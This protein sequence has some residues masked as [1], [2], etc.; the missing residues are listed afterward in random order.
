MNGEAMTNL[1]TS[2]GYGSGDFALNLF[3]QGTGFYLFFYFTDVVG[4]P[5]AVAGTV[6]AIGG[7]WDAITDPAMGYIAERTKSRW[8][9]YRPYLL[10]GSVPLGLS[11]VL[12]FSLPAIKG[13]AASWVVALLALLLFRTC[14]T[15]VSIPYST[16]GARMTTN[17]D[18]RTHLSAIRMYCAFLGGMAV[19]GAAALLQSYYPDG[20]VFRYLGIF[21]AVTGTIVL[22]LC[23]RY[24]AQRVGRN[25]QALPAT[26]FRQLM[27]SLMS[28]R[29]FL[30][31]LISIVFVSAATTVVTSTVL[32]IFEYAFDDRLMGNNAILIMT[33]APL[34][35]IPIWSAVAL[36]FGKKNTWITG[37]AV[38]IIGLLSLYFYASG[39][40]YSALFSYGIITLGLSSFSVLFWSMLPDTIEYGEYTTGVRNESSIIGFVSSAQKAALAASVFL[41][42]LMLDM[43]GY[44][45]G[46]E[47]TSETLNG[48]LTVVC[49]APGLAMVG[50]IIAMVYYP[51]T[52]RSHAEMVTVL[53]ENDG[54]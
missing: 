33:G 3:W 23:F 54:L 26:S 31:L 1:K 46:V 4:L 13:S 37:C 7:L 38:T 6:F 25:T 35:T 5:N 22:F 36:K 39:S 29:P 48:L 19:I 20:E 44:S 10:F 21:C 12:L 16:L 50:A 9:R 18:E 28:N 41:L 24:T 17:S 8:G 51:I 47:Q 32:Y 42:G 45:A 52:A 40:V 43:V 30:V 34:I 27:T 11:L 2:I 15:V 14:Y 53:S 49:L